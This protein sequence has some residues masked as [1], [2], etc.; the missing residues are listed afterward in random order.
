M[1]SISSLCDLQYVLYVTCTLDIQKPKKKTFETSPLQKMEQTHI[2]KAEAVLELERFRVE[3]Q[4]PC[5]EEN[6]YTANN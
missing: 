2:S 3:W 1:F 4:N 6:N 5:S